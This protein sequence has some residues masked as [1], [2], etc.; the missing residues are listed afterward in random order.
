M[1]GQFRNSR[2][3]FLLR[4]GLDAVWILLT[5]KQLPEAAGPRQGRRGVGTPLRLLVLG[6]SAAAGVGVDTQDQALAGRLLSELQ[7]NYDVS[8]EVLAKSGATTRSCL[9]MIKKRDRCSFDAVVV[10]IG[11]N[12]VKNGVTMKD[13][14]RNMQN[15]LQ[16]L[17]EEYGNPNVYLSALPPV[18]ELLALPPALRELLA[19]RR[20]RFDIALQHLAN[21]TEQTS[22]IPFDFDFSQGD[23]ASDRFHPGRKTYALWAR[24]AAVELRRHH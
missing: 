15:L 10:S 7:S 9:Q 1:I 18:R 4:A 20:D 3:L 11:L 16:I 12:D 8:W 14:R 23:L 6:D 2:I 5:V 19:R 13:W 24:I 21:E 17:R 22:F